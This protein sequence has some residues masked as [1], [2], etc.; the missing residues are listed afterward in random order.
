MPHITR[1]MHEAE[2][3]TCQSDA[4]VTHDDDANEDDDGS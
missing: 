2:Y 3:T 4:N 1:I